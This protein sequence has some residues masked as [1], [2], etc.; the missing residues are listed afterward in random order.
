MRLKDKVCIITGAGHRLRLNDK[1][2]AIVIDW[3]KSHNRPH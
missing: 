3:L 1:A 2:M